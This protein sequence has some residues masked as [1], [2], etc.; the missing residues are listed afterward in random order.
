MD[1][2]EQ[3]FENECSDTNWYNGKHVKEMEMGQKWLEHSVRLSDVESGV[4][5]ALAVRH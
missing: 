4:R 1:D 2:L 5:E 3:V